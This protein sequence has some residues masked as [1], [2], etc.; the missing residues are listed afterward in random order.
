M[1]VNF[2]KDYDNNSLISFHCFWRRDFWKV[3]TLPPP[4]PNLGGQKNRRMSWDFSLLSKLAPMVRRTE[5]NIDY[6]HSH[7]T[8]QQTN[9]MYLKETYQ[10]NA[11][12][13]FKIQKI[14]DWWM[15]GLDGWW[16]ELKS[17]LSV[18]CSILLVGSHVVLRSGG[19][20]DVATR[21]GVRRY[22]AHRGPMVH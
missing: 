21:S 8:D 22:Q 9:N 5:Y 19:V 13:K 10:I 4:T 15:H 12:F 18:Q 11:P 2:K 1:G 16:L 6:A 7:D 14:L 17:P 20:V 3:D